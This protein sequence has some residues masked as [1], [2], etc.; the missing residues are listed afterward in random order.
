MFKAIG[1]I[2]C[3][4]DY[5]YS[6]HCNNGFTIYYIYSCEKCG[7]RKIENMGR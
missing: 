7:K 6:N 4:H 1:K 2:L 5:K 3:V